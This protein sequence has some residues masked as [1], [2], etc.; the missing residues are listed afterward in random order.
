MVAFANFKKLA[1]PSSMP[2]NKAETKKIDSRGGSVMEIAENAP[3]YK[4]MASN[5]KEWESDEEK[6]GTLKGRKSEEPP[7]RVSYKVN[8]IDNSQRENN[9]SPDFSMKNNVKIIPKNKISV[10]P[11]SSDKPVQIIMKVGNLFL[12]NIYKNGESKN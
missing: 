10:Q 9:S 3:H 4:T 1:F 7:D 6:K 12:S 8:R 5:K 2:D 11:Q